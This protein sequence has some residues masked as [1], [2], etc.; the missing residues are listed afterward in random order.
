MRLKQYQS[1]MKSLLRQAGS[2]LGADARPI[3]L[4]WQVE[5]SLERRLK[6]LGRVGVSSEE[7][8]VW[9]KDSRR[10]HQL[11]VGI[12][13][14]GL[15]TE[16]GEILVTRIHP[17]PIVGIPTFWAVRGDEYRRFYR[18]IRQMTKSA[19][20]EFVEPLMRTSDRTRLWDNTIGFLRLDHH[21]LKRY[22]VPRKRGVLLSGE[23]GNG[24]TMACRW[25]HA[26]CERIGLMWQ[27]VTIDEYERARREGEIHEL[28]QPNRPGIVLF[29][30]FDAALRD[31]RTCDNPREQS[32]F[33]AEIDGMSPKHGVVFLFTSN[34]KRDEL[35][36]A[37]RRPGR[38]DQ[39]ITFG[40][41]TTEDRRRLIEERWHADVTAQLD[42][43][44]V[45]DATAG[46]S[47]AQLEEVKKLLVLSF[48][49]R[50][51]TDWQAACLTVNEHE[52]IH[53][54]RIAGFATQVDSADGPGATVALDKQRLDRQRLEM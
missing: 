26:Q 43:A 39:I 41:P 16:H 31:R 27:S 30:D 24:K 32:T 13:I 44:S 5:Q 11:L 9:I 4:D 38:I 19:R 18:A 21:E 20:A 46:M 47:F 54:G 42:V 6:R 12:Q 7:Y 37:I 17:P 40:K 23:P 49:E 2:L 10:G 15:E 3:Q 25:L 1:D 52:G 22:G 45:V 50:G 33:L 34:L 35:D 8:V 53:H 14:Y 28:F 29:D 51:Q 48:I 36:V